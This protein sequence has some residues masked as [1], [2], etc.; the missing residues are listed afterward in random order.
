MAL[1]QLLGT[2]SCIVF[3]LDCGTS[4]DYMSDQKQFE[5]LSNHC[6]YPFSK[7]ISG[8]DNEDLLSE[9][10]ETL[11]SPYSSSNDDA[12]ALVGSMACIGVCCL[13]RGY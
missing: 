13:G 3:K 5:T 11:L 2:S 4:N 9:I 8:M 6:Q 7:T 10:R 1:Q 12:Q